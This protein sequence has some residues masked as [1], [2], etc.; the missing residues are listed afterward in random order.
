MAWEVAVDTWVAVK[1]VTVSDTT[2]YDVEVPRAVEETVLV[3]TTV[4]LCGRV[5]VEV[6]RNSHHVNVLVNGQYGVQVKR[7]TAAMEQLTTL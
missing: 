7:L 5:T 4:S 2:M 6:D 3:A 1:S